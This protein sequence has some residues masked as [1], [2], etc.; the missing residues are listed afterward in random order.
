MARRDH[1]IES[2]VI[3]CT[4]DAVESVV[5][6]VSPCVSSSLPHQPA[7]DFHHV[8]Q[9]LILESAFMIQIAVMPA[10]CSYKSCDKSSF[11]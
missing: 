3:A 4:H 1:S 11:S 9:A 7:R 5:I 2:N 6:Q 8:V 10:G